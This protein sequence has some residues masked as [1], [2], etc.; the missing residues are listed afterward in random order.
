M[1]VLL[2]LGH[3]G[4]VWGHKVALFGSRSSRLYDSCCLSRAY[5]LR[6]WMTETH[7]RDSILGTCTLLSLKNF[8]HRPLRC[9]LRHIGP[10][11]L[12]WSLSFS[13]QSWSGP[14]RLLCAA[15]LLG[16][17]CGS[18]SEGSELHPKRILCWVCLIEIPQDAGSQR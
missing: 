5:K 14:S 13:P 3:L 6:V 7:C 17:T 2:L 1:K 16:L 12:C 10:S 8:S 9:D 11:L 15:L 4:L 18:L